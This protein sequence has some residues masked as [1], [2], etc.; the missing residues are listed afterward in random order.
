MTKIVFLTGTRADYGK[1]KALIRKLSANKNFVVYVYV[2]GMHLLK[3]FG[4]T[5]K[6]IVEDGYAN[7]YVE[8]KNEISNRM[9][10][11][12]AN[13]I[14]QFSNY[15]ATIKPDYIAVHGDRTDAMAGA[16]VGLL[17]NIKVVHIEGGELT[18]T[19]DDS[20]R[21]AITKLAH[22]HCTANEETKY[23]LMQLGEE[24]GH[25]HIIGSPDIDLMLSDAIP[26]VSYVKAKYGIDFDDFSILMYHPVVT[27]IEDIDIKINTIMKAIDTSN[28]NYIVVYP[29]NDAGSDCII[30]C[31]KNYQKKG[32]H[33]LYFEESFPFEE[34][35]SLLK[36]ADFIIGNSSAGI[37]EACIYGVPCIDIGSRQ[38]DRYDAHILRNIQH[39]D[40]QLED[41][42]FAIRQVD[43]FRHKSFYFGNGDS[44]ELFEQAIDREVRINSLIQKRFVDLDET[45]TR[46][47]KY[48]NEVLF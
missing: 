2:T 26:D 41:I 44:A 21:H 8:H 14:L 30:R 34:F 24:E 25:I 36:N 40:E 16:V 3:Q 43:Q 31:Y 35:L 23:R 46:I 38:N 27:E 18:G 19:V 15:I 47:K 6:Q 42:L 12:L 11:N 45:Q 28:K 13:T 37:R 32:Q 39:V 29:N 10:V 7:V 9:D 5:W 33:K 48:I 17:N 20:L 4:S 22:V 1:I